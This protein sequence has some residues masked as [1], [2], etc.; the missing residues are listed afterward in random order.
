MGASRPKPSNAAKPLHTALRN[1]FLRAKLMMAACFRIYRV[2]A[3]GHVTNMNPYAR[4]VSGKQWYHV[5]FTLHRSRGL[6]KIPATAR[7]CERA[8]AKECSF[9]EWNV[10]C[11]SVNPNQIRLLNHTVSGLSRQA[12][13]HA[14][15]HAASR[16]V[17]RSGAVPPGHRVWGPAAWCF[18]LR[19]EANVP[20]LRNR[21]KSLSTAGADW[22]RER[23]DELPDLNSHTTTTVIS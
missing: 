3:N 23:T 9:P 2:A 19:N 13:L 8:I 11:V 22:C 20:S 15:K 4:P 5:I 1:G 17:R 21:L 16:A 10:D 12:V 7:F 14:I 18:P 6:L